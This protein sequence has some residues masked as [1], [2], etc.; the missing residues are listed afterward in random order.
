MSENARAARL[1]LSYLFRS[2]PARAIASAALAVLITVGALVGAVVLK[3]LTD[4]ALAGDDGQVIVAALLVVAN[5]AIMITGNFGALTVSMKLREKATLY[6]DTRMA[7]L[8][9]GI[10]HLEHHERPD[11]LNELSVLQHNHQQLAGLQ[12]ALISQLTTILRLGTAVLLLA[13][14]HPLLMLLPVAGV[15]S[16]LVTIRK[17]RHRQEVQDQVAPRRRLV[18]RLFTIA[19]T[20]DA[21]KEV[22]LYDIGDDLLARSDAAR[23]EIY[24]LEDRADRQAA[25][26]GGLGWLAFGAGIVAAMVLVAREAAAGRATAGDVVM[27]LSLAGS[28]NWGVSGLAGS[29]GWVLNNLKT[30]KRLA[31]LEDFAAEGAARAKPESPAPVPAALGD[32]IRLE[33][34]S[35]AYPSAE[36]D[37]AAEVLHGVDLFFPAGSTVAMVGDNG[38]G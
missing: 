32:G 12:E 17:E 18:L 21:A 1:V 22:R 10:H 38:A 2:D 31:W 36:G 37:G 34:V 20:R 26:Y 14:V 13:R 30:G 25:L 3:V 33:G 16:G 23:A 11:Y 7:E 15:P 4:A 27:A 19:T 5:T 9:A 35:F 8:A 24:E 29:A 28:I 6:F